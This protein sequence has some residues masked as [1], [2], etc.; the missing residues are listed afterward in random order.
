MLFQ[1]F[2]VVISA[3]SRLQTEGHLMSIFTRALSSD[4]SPFNNDEIRNNMDSY[5]KS[6]SCSPFTPCLQLFLLRASSQSFCGYCNL[7]TNH[8]GYVTDQTVPPH[9]VV[10][11]YHATPPS[12]SA[13]VVLFHLTAMTSVAAMDY[14]GVTDTQPYTGTSVQIRHGKAQHVSNCAS[15]LQVSKVLRYGREFSPA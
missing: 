14:A 1:S 10:N 12:R 2:C 4:E 6:L 8:S 13:C 7:Y 9:P 15:T 11:I 3:I 5:T